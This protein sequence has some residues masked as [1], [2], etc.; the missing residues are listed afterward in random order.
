VKQRSIRGTRRR[1]LD[2][3]LAGLDQQ[4]GQRPA[5]GWISTIRDAL[6][7][8][9]L[10]LAFRLGVCPSR[11]CQMERAELEGSLRLGTLRNAAAA[12]NCDLL[13]VLVP[14]MPLDTMVRQ[15][16]EFQAR[17]Q[18]AAEQDAIERER[19]SDDRDANKVTND[20]LEARTERIAILAD[21]LA[22][23]RGLWTLRLL[24]LSR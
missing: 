5:V 21:E 8:S 18:I 24:S 9:Q 11:V 13:Y 19:A 3:R 12:M 20:A 23:S 4:I 1:R 16:A 10:E 14:R 17:V 15:Q 22:E 6:G 2:E 7:M